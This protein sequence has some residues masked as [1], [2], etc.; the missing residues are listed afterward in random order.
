M[1]LA[2]SLTRWQRAFLL[3]GA[4]MLLMKAIAGAL[5]TSYGTW[6]DIETVPLVLAVFLAVIA[7][8][9]RRAG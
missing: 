1:R 6:D 8:S 4:F 3:I 9:P 7:I 2:I 5:N